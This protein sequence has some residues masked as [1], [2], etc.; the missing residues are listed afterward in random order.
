MKNRAVFLLGVITLFVFASC[1]TLYNTKT[2]DIE[3]I[4]PSVLTISPEFR[5]IAVQYNNVNCSPNKYLNQYEEFGT[6]KT[7]EENSDSIAS[8]IYFE[9][10]I[11]ELNNQ[12]FFDTLL[13]LQER[14]YSTTKVLDTINYTPFFRE[15]SATRV[16]MTTEQINVFNSSYFLQTNTSSVQSKSD[17]L[18]MHPQFGLYT[19][20]QLQ[21]IRNNT[22]ANLLLSL[23]FFGA[24]DGRFFYRQFEL[25]SELVTNWTQWSFYDLIKMKYVLAYS[26]TDT[27]KWMEYSSSQSKAD[28]LLPPRTDAIYNAAEISAE[29]FALS[30]VP[31]WVQV[32]RMYYSSGHVELQQTDELIQ[33]AQWKEAAQLWDNQLNNKNKKIVAKCM[34]NLGLACEMEGDLEAALAWVVKSYHIFGP[35]NE[36]H[37]ENCMQYIRLL[38]TRQADMKLLELQF[39]DQ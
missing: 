8:R 22:G 32:Q 12:A 31:H 13:T 24:S 6:Q 34:Y 3:I 21:S 29:N 26:K 16:T 14:N 23:D 28:D 39:G 38:S 30:I 37:A 9:N 1:N 5:N 7:E 4:E 17:S 18:I 10:C 20:E 33:N 35:R 2:I 15:D 19:P 36:L 27:V 11:S 25:G